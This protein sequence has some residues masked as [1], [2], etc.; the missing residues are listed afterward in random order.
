[1]IT[2]LRHRVLI[3]RDSVKTITEGG[4]LIPKEAEKK[5]TT[6]TVLSVGSTA[7][8]QVKAGQRVMFGYHDGFEV[9]PEYCEGLENCLMIAD[10]QIRVILDA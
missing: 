5:E 9:A 1:M 2:P 7:D 10:N 6:G 8:E 3:Q 4:L